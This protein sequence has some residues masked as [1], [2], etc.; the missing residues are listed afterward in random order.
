MSD[1]ASDLLAAACAYRRSMA[2]VRAGCHPLESDTR[3]WRRF[4]LDCAS[5]LIARGC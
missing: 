1:L 5:R 3:F 2:L 4:A